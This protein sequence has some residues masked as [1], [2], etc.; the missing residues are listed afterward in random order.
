MGG[1]YAFGSVIKLTPSGAEK[2][3]Y[4]FG[5]FSNPNGGMVSD[6]SGRFYGTTEQGGGTGCSGYGCGTIFEVTG[7][8][9]EKTLAAFSEF[10]G[11]C[12]PFAGLIRDPAGH[13]YGT[14]TNCGTHSDGTVFAIRP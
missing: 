6:G 10:T 8:G 2:L 13:L 4:S 1:A 3:L 14:T 5:E 11:G 7:A 9:D 12:V